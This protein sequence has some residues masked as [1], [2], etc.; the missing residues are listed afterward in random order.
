MHCNRRALAPSVPD[1]VNFRMAFRTPRGSVTGVLV[2]RARLDCRAEVVSYSSHQQREIRYELRRRDLAEAANHP[3]CSVDFQITGVVAIYPKHQSEASAPSC[4]NAR[5]RILH[6]RGIAWPFVGVQPCKTLQK[7]SGL[8]FPRRFRRSLTSPST[9]VLNRFPNPALSTIER[10]FLL[11][12]ASPV[13]TP[14]E[15]SSCGQNGSHRDQHQP[16]SAAIVP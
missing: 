14:Q 6:D 12:E 1:R 5:N 11:D 3:V 10:A 2:L 13:R 9:T 15:R 7:I 16:P 8:G 4:L